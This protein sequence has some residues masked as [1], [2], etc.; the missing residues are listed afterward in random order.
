[1]ATDEESAFSGEEQKKQIPRSARN[2]RVGDFI[3]IGGPRAHVTLQHDR[4]PFF[5]SLLD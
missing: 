4:Q 5:S 1:M 3:H 2:D